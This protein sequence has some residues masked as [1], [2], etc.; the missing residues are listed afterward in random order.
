MKTDKEIVDEL[1]EKVGYDQ[2]FN[3]PDVKRILRKA[4]QIKEDEIIK[5]IDN[6]SEYVY[7]ETE[8]SKHINSVDLVIL[9]QR[10]KGK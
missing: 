2:G 3:H 8:G 5:E 10:I 6:C 4:L 7:N 9:K 1:F